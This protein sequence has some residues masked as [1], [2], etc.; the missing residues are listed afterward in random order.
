[1]FQSFY[2]SVLR[3]NYFSTQFLFPV[4]YQSGDL[5]CEY[6]LCFVLET[7][8][9]CA[10]SAG[11]DYAQ[12]LQLFTWCCKRLVTRE[13]ILDSSNDWLVWQVRTHKELKIPGEGAEKLLKKEIQHSRHS[14]RNQEVKNNKNNFGST[15]QTKSSAIFSFTYKGRWS[16]DSREAW[17]KCEAGKSRSR[18][19]G[20]RSSRETSTYLE[21]HP[22]ILNLD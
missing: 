18:K 2:L 20:L 11:D 5:T 4:V 17:P 13:K 21:I 8:G 14:H 12:E 22:P 15:A 19:D 7:F 1:M 6:E 10:A 16:K 9:L 3:I